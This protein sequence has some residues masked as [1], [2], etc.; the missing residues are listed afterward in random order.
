MNF[1]AAALPAFAAHVCAAAATK[2]FGGQQIIFLCLMTGRGFLVF[3]ELSLYTVKE[4]FGNDG[5]DAVRYNDIAESVLAR[6]S[7]DCSTY[8]EYCYN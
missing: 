5:W 3:G 6:C 8:V 4:F 1:A 7:V 2:Q